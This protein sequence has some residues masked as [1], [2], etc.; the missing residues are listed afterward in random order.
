LA[1]D[2]V[3]QLRATQGAA[4]HHCALPGASA[5]KRT[6]YIDWRI[7]PPSF[8]RMRESR[9]GKNHWIPVFAG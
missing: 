7:R 9:R 1:A 4:A 8:P 2:Q 6:S 5:R 3:T